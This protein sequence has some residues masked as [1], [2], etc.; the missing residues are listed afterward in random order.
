[1][2]QERRD[3][4]RRWPQ[5]APAGWTDQLEYPCRHRV[6]LVPGETHEHLAVIRNHAVD[7]DVLG[8]RALRRGP[9]ESNQVWPGRHRRCQVQR[10]RGSVVTGCRKRHSLCRVATLIRSEALLENRQVGLAEQ[11]C[12]GARRV[13]GPR[14]T[15]R[16]LLDRVGHGEG[17][18]QH[19]VSLGTIGE[20]WESAASHR[21]SAKMNAAAAPPPAGAAS[22]GEAPPLSF[23]A[24]VA[25][26]GGA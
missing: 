8:K 13:A 16:E 2:Q 22:S 14:Q 25:G 11:A 5:R 9:H 4:A 24:A 26:L 17:V 21:Y 12:D 6:A 23:A 18:V 3:E 10:S 15:T 7:V 1:M 19:G 20:R